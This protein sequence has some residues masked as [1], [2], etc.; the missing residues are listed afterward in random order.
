MELDPHVLHVAIRWV[1]VAAMATAFGGA[2]TVLA[3][4]TRPAGDPASAVL[5]VAIRYEWMFWAAAGVLVMTGIGNL[6]AF[7]ADLSGPSTPWGSTLMLKLGS[8]LALVILSLPR[9]LAVARMSQAAGSTASAVVWLRN[10]YGA[11][12]A[13]FAVILGLAVWLAHG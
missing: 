12:T 6:A 8:V 5:S 1:H 2:I 10:L 13:A 9:T 3:L 4:A 11:T 7:G